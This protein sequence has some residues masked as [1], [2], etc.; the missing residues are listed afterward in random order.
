MQANPWNNPEIN[1]Q[2]NV[3]LKQD[4]KTQLWS[5]SATA[6]GC[7]PVSGTAADRE[8]AKQAVAMAAMAAT[9]DQANNYVLTFRAP[10]PT[11][12]AVKP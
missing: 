12:A 4:P 11:A 9:D 3:T 6:P 5:W 8:A 10:M 2:W 1:V 7:S